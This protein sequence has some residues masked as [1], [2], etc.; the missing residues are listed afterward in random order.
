MEKTFL[1]ELIERNGADKA[2]KIGN[3]VLEETGINIDNVLS[4]EDE[5]KIRKYLDGLW[6]ESVLNGVFG[7]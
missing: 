4:K 7:E 3:K 2:L 1:H 5:I 6:A